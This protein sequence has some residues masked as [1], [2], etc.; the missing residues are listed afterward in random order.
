MSTL[1]SSVIEPATGTNLTLGAAGDLITVP[2]DSIQ[3]NTWK[4][5][6]G[7][8]IFAS[9]GAGNLSSVNSALSLGGGPKLIQSQT[10][11]TDTA[12]ISFTTGLDN[13]YKKYMFVWTD[14]R[15]STNMVDFRFQGSQDGGTN[16]NCVMQTAMTRC[17]ELDNS[18]SSGNFF[19]DTG[20]DQANGTAFQ[21][22]AEQLGNTYVAATATSGVRPGGSGILYLY[23]P[24][25]T[26]DAKMFHAQMQNYYG[27][28]GTNSL[29]LS[30]Y[31]NTLIAITA[32][33]FKMSSGN[34][35]N[36]K[37]KLYGIR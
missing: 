22:L 11:T 23:D 28:Y 15:P 35:A 13:T 25:S 3:L 16:Y 19:Y 27:G 34:I 24:S 12:T 14:V 37:I 20:Q 6:G 21:G 36:A 9:D 1:K 31:F 2:S 4:D 29:F 5:S 17:Y 18:Q 10:V 7:N 33:Q 26:T 8:T 30:G 32:I